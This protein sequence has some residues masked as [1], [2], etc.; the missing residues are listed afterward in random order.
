[1]V[2]IPPLKPNKMFIAVVLLLL[3]LIYILYLI[4]SSVS[5]QEKLGKYPW[6]KESN[7]NHIKDSKTGM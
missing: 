7:N 4:F 2:N 5:I 3:L 6:P 1:M